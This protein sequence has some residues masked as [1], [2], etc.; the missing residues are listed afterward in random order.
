[1]DETERISFQ[2]PSCKRRVSV[3]GRAAGKRGKCPGCGETVDVPQQTAGT[4]PPAASLT[5]QPAGSPTAQPAASA[6]ARPAART[7]ASPAAAS[8]D[9]VPI[10]T[11]AGNTPAWHGYV[12]I[13][14]AILLVL[15]LLIGAVAAG[16][17]YGSVV[18]AVLLVVVAIAIVP[19]LVYLFHFTPWGRSTLQ[20]MAK[21]QKE[22]QKRQKE[23]AAAQAKA[24][25]S[26][27][28]D[29]VAL[30]VAM[31]LEDPEKLQKLLARDLVCPKCHRRFRAS[32]ALAEVEG[33]LFGFSLPGLVCPLCHT[34]IGRIGGHS[35]M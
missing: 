25:D 5:A 3:T 16:A 18:L 20:A 11:A 30:L 14:L 7:V 31:Q 28:V 1:M 26:D 33:G 21:A 17:D 23:L 34:T 9:P 15:I 22:Q 8:Y 32:E 2:C 13:G 29:P 24:E 10:A 6:K 12:L 4:V 19:G 35:I 27:V